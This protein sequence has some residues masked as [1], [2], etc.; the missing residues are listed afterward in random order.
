MKLNPTK[1]SF[2]M[3]EGKFLKVITTG[4]GFKANLDKVQAVARMFSPSS[5]KEVQTLNRKLVALNRFLAN[6][7]TK[8]Y[9]FV[10]TLRNCLKKAHFKWTAESEQAF[11][12]VKKCLMEL[13]TL[14]TPY[15]GE[16][17]TLCLSASDIAIVAVLLTDRKNVQTPFYYV[18]RTLSDP[19]TRPKDVVAKL[20]NAGYYWAGMHLDAVQVIRKCDSYQRHAP[21]TLRSKNE[22]VP[23]TS[24]WPFQKWAIDIMGPFPEAPGRVKFLIVAIDYFTKWVEAKPVA[25]ITTSSIK[26]FL[27]EFIICRFGL[28]Q[29]LVSEN[30]T[31]FAGI[32]I[33]EWLKK[34]QV[35]Q[36]FTSVAHPQANGQVERTNRTIKE[37]IKARLGTKC[38]G[39][40]D[41]L[42]H[43]LWAFRTQNN[44]SNSETPFSLTYD[45]LEE[46]RELASIHEHNYKHQLQKYYNSRV[47]KCTFD[48][49]DSSSAITNLPA[50]N[51]QY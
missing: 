15:V 29:E 41:E 34:L 14:T 47:Q 38:T 49:G 30:G 40:V 11:L 17:L 45:L 7:S 46:R 2:G 48:A 24:A 19:E 35:I 6:H 28:P 21:N 1:F 23:V 10:S 18:S 27:W 39:W 13:P 50:K 26:K 16:P 3:E 8:S 5:L 51:L 4:A 12:E 43:V 37:G 42:P 44:S 22:L 9:P 31:Q 36:N 25:S 32:G 20:M 33:Q